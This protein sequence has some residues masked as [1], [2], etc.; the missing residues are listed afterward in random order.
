MLC[1]VQQLV[2][3]ISKLKVPSSASHV[4]KKSPALVFALCFKFH[5]GSC[6]S[7]CSGEGRGKREEGR[8]KREVQLHVKV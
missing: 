2:D 3:I 5:S 6:G 7:N 1:L 4:P 8:G